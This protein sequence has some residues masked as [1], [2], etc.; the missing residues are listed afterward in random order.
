MTAVQPGTETGRLVRSSALV[1]LGTALSRLTGLVRV[2]A[3]TYALGTT[4]AAESYNLAN[5]TPNI[6][7][8]LL[9]GGILSATLG[10]GVRR[11]VPDRRRRGHVS[12]RHRSRSRVMV[13]ITVVAML[14]APLIFRIYPSVSRTVGP[15]AWRR[16]ACRSCAFLPQILFYGL[17][18]LGTALLNAR[19]SLRRAGVRPG[20]EQHRGEHRCC[21]L[22]PGWPKEPL[23]LAR[24]VRDH[25]R[26][27]RCSG[28]A[29]RRASSP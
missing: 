14:A 11:A 23:S 12:G 18:A 15:T 4:A 28:S 22:C 5:N 29:R 1:G 20:A 8:E 26:C 3:I 6:V 7:Y 24:S 19:K 2:F 16:S 27:S 9:L 21:W 10:P 17:T 13:A 25:R